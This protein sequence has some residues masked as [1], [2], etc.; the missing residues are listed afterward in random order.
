MHRRSV[1]QKVRL[2]DRFDLTLECIRRHH[3][4]EDSPISDTLTRCCGV[5]DLFVD[6]RGYTEFF[7]L[8]DLV[9]EN[10]DAVNFHL[11]FDN[12]ESSPCPNDFDL[13]KKYKSRVLKFVAARNFRILRLL[14]HPRAT[15]LG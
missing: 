9:T 6:F 15:A 13:Y 14:D 10:F 5:F 4:N 11:P 3:Q 7:L 8:R 1:A 2:G 12:F